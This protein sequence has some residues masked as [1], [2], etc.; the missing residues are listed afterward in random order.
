VGLDTRAYANDC[1]LV[2]GDVSHSLAVIERTLRELKK[3]FL[4]VFFVPG[5]HELWLTKHER[6]ELGI[7]DSV[8]KARAVQQACEALGVHTRP[9]KVSGVWVVPLFS[10]YHASWDRDPAPVTGPPI[11]QCMTDFALCRWPSAPGSA[12]DADGMAAARLLDSLN[13]PHV[14][15]A[16]SAIDC[17][18]R[19]G[20][21]PVVVSMSHFLPLQELLPERRVLS[22]PSLPRACGSDLLLRRVLRLQPTAHVFG[23]THFEWDATICGTR[24]VQW[25]M[26]YPREQRGG[27]MRQPMMLYDTA[28][29]SHGPSMHSPWSAIYGGISRPHLRPSWFDDELAHNAAL[30]SDAL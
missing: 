19:E 28:A 23:H 5:N 6:E 8:H 16:V 26:G 15:E 17:E 18:R 10:W 11:E 30:C 24:Y 4:H 22:L 29:G 27:S 1:L 7:A 14:D 20:Q 21:S 2:A 13:A 9:A 12:V 3:R 25:P